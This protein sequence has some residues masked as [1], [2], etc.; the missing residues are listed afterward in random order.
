[1]W[2]MIWPVVIVV[3][4]N[5]FYNIC[6]KSTPNGINAFGTLLV[7]YLMAAV[8]TAVLF[9]ATAGVTNVPGELKKLNW[10]SFI[11]GV[12]IVGLEVGYVFL[13]RAGWKVSAGSVVCNI[14]LAVVLVFVGML[15]YKETITL[16]QILGMVL[17]S[18]GLVLITR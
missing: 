5:V 11:L 2:D 6:Q 14:A 18:A 10:T 15:L 3:L 16:K 12:A 9:V 13:Y 1:M 8:I 7:T 4:S 17:C